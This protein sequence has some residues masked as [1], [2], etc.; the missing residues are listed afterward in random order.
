MSCIH[1]L[2]QNIYPSLLPL[3]LASL[4]FFKVF[5]DKLLLNQSASYSNLAFSFCLIQ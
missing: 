2:V 3:F 1:P 5:L 4:F